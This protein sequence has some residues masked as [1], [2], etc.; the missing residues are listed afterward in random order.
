MASTVLTQVVLPAV[1]EIME[2]RARLLPRFG[3]CAHGTRG[4][5]P[6]AAEAHADD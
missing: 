2:E 4:L 3:P 1:Y 5:I 6:A